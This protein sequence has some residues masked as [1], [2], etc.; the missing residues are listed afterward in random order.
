MFTSIVDNPKKILLPKGWEYRY[1]NDF[2]VFYY[3]IPY[4]DGTNGLMFEK[5]IIFKNDMV[6]Q[7]KVYNS[8]L[9]L[10]N[11]GI[12]VPKFPTVEDITNLINS[13]DEYHIC[14]GGPLDKN[15]VDIP[16]SYASLCINGYWR[17]GN[18]R[19]FLDSKKSMTKR[20]VPCLNL[21]S[22][23]RMKKKRMKN[24]KLILE[25]TS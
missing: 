25:S 13:I 4:C 7:C 20:C 15:Y 23:F 14:V 18:C 21:A 9:D 19:Y 17:H 6:I 2:V 3:V 5:Q 8:D 12:S 22:A 10:N 16:N 24:K 11:F 1:V